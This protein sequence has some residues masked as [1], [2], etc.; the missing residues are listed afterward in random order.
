MEKF[1]KTPIILRTLD[2]LDIAASLYAPANSGDRSLVGG[3]VFSHMMPATKESWEIPAIHFAEK[4]Y[5]GLSIDLRGHGESS[6]GPKSYAKFTDEEHQ[7]SILDLDSAAKFLMGKGLKAEEIIF[8]GASIGAN[9]SLKYIADNR[10]FKSTILLSPGLDYRGI[11]AEQLSATLAPRQR[12]FIISSRDDGGNA[13]EAKIIFSA[14]KDG[15][16]KRLEIFETGGHGTDIM[17]HQPDALKMIEE[18][19]G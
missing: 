8:M 12:V 15:V 17:K 6:G 5:L 19:I 10:D 3:M 2:G 1:E 9:L 13:E 16:E 11:E 7:K 14:I 18:F 4:G